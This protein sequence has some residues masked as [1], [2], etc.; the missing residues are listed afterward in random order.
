MTR[1][2]FFARRKPSAAGL[3]DAR[4][5]REASGM[6]RAPR[7]RAPREVAPRAWASG[8]QN[9]AESMKRA[10]GF[11]AAALV[12][13]VL[14]AGAACST[15]QSAGQQMDDSSIHT[16]IK[17]KLAA[18]RSSNLVNVDVNVTNGVV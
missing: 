1:H 12:A 15:T 17:A 5:P 11:F 4:E 14:A 8:P 10:H 7:T 18:D 16:A 6:R 3:A 2:L 9:G 13:L